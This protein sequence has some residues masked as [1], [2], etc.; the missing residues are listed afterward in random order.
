LQHQGQVEAVAYSPDGQS[1]VTGSFDGTVRVWNTTTG[2]SLG[3]ALR[4]QGPVRAVAFSPD[5]RTILTG[6]DDKTARLWQPP[7]P[8]QGD[9]KRMVLWIQVETGME[10]DAGGVVHVLD[11][12]TWQERRQG[13]Q[14]LGGPP[15]P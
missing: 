3:A 15:L 12:P 6:S 13:L 8:L 10:L 1:V 7:A 2:Q 5:G 9:V 11:A 4:H 14:E